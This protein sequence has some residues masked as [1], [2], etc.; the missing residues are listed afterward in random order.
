MNA[1]A[2]R[3]ADA[4][5]INPWQRPDMAVLSAGRG[6]P[7]PMPTDMF[8]EAWPLIQALGEGAGAPV[9]YV[10]SSVL[11]VAASLIGGKRR[12]RPFS[13]SDWEEPCILWIANVGDPSSNKSPGQDAATKPLRSIEGDYAGTHRRVLQDYETKLQRAKAERKKWEDQ[14]S[15][16]TK[17]GDET[18]MLPD[19]AILPDEPVRRRLMV[20]DATPEAM[21]PVLAGNP[22]G[23]LHFRDE[24]AGWLM[25]FERYSPGGREFWL[26]AFGGRPHVIDRK[27]AAKPLIIPFNGVS[28][29]GGIQPEKLSEC[30]LS[31]SDDGLVARFLW[32]WPAPIPYHRPRQIADAG[33]LERLYRRLDRIPPGYGPDGQPRPIMLSLSD[34][35]ADIF[36]EWVRESSEALVDAASLYKSFCGKLR[37]VVLRLALVTE[38]MAWA[39][40]YEDREPDE[41]GYKSLVAA[42]E[43]V[44][45]YAKPTALRVFGDAALPPVER[46]AATL[47]RY[48]LKQRLS[49]INVREISRSGGMPT[50]KR[51]PDIAEAIDHLVEADWLRP[52]PSR[53]GD[54]AGRA[55]GDFDVNPAVH[56]ARR[57]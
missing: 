30:L 38:M 40:G 45:S 21:G 28:V 49:Q 25:S 9:D 17:S 36:E 37:G 50:L 11:S 14:V 31:G 15:A 46:N 2:A 6:T 33:A 47:A 42:I 23:T 12:V 8:G 22:H 32:A 56:E 43:Y 3:L 41:I 24:L 39:F 10:A 44:E 27:G 57:A 48:I 53:A 18:P 52:A 51:A 4:Q 5:T 20:Q 54:S 55:K 7:A 16:A 13:T 34:Q 26:E 35:A 19:A 29:L 1:L